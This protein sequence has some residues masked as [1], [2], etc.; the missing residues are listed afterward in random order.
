M[1]YRSMNEPGRVGSRAGRLAGRA[2]AVGGRPLQRD[3]RLLGSVDVKRDALALAAP[4]ALP[5]EE[6]ARTAKI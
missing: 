4:R 3:S 1:G 2:R 5:Q 6:Q